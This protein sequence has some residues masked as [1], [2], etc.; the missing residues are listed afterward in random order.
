MF[1]P[2]TLF[3][4]EIIAGDRQSALRAEA[5]GERLLRSLRVAAGRAG[6]RLGRADRPD[7]AVAAPWQSCP[8]CS[9]AA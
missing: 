9:L 6:G 7:V 8:E 1:E 4:L 2:V 3:T 5:A